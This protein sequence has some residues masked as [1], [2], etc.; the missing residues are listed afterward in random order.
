MIFVKSFDKKLKYYFNIVNNEQIKVDKKFKLLSRYIRHM[1]ISFVTAPFDMVKQAYGVKREVSYGNWLPFGLTVLAGCCRQAGHKPEIVDSPPLK[2]TNADVIAHL[3]KSQPDVVGLQAAMATKEQTMQLL[4]EIK[5]NLDVPVFL[6]GWLASFKESLLKQNP[7]IDFVFVGEAEKAIVKTL[8]AL[9]K[10]ESFKNI[11]GVCY[12]DGERAINNGPG[13]IVENLDE[14]PPPAWDLFDLK[15]YRS[16]PLQTKRFPAVTYLSSRG[17]SYAR[18][19]FCFH[20]GTAGPKYRRHSPERVVS[21]IKEVV[22]KYGAKE[23]AFWDDIF[24]INEKWILEFCRLLKQ[25]K[26]DV[27]WQGYGHASFVTQKMLNEAAKA[28]CWGI[29]YGFE[30]GN[31]SI[32]D[33]VQKGQTLEKMSLAAKWTHEA[34]MD[35]RGSFIMALPG[36]TPEMAM[37]TAQWAADNKLTFVQFLTFFPEHGTKLYEDLVKENKI[38]EK[39]KGR[40]TP[41][42]VPSGYKNAEE[43]QQTLKKMYRKF[44]YRPSFI[45]KHLKRIKS[46][47]DFKQ[48][49]EAFMYISKIAFK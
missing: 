14:L 9:E 13:E 17:C 7:E 30:S 10:G 44:H 26:V 8:N 34:G 3:K 31:Q 28:G 29:F 22:E 12:R 42:Y 24:I 37:K 41:H 43:V 46:L 19:T 39:Y 38:S 18:C 49:Y 33:N 20:G 11:K 36:E 23:V 15:N 48:Y 32:L 2:Y 45:L 6:G 47:E 4:H 16:L 40:T 25:E 1:K 21:D 35:T 5:V 27:A